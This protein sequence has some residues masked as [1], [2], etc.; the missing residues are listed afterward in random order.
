[1]HYL[2]PSNSGHFA[3]EA[4]GQGWLG[5][6]DGTG[7]AVSYLHTQTSSTVG[8]LHHSSGT[9]YLPTLLGAV[10]ECPFPFLFSRPHVTDHPL[11]LVT[12]A[13]VTVSLWTSLLPNTVYNIDHSW[14]SFLGGFAFPV[15]P[16]PQVG[17]KC[18][19]S[20]YTFQQVPAILAEPSINQV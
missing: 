2:Y 15:V 3:P 8:A 17:L 12:A 20:Y 4:I 19:I 13:H 18:P 16:W 1:M 10:L 9:K 7:Q 11:K 5:K 6:G 14:F